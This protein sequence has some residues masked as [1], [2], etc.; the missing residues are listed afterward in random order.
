MKK[1]LLVIAVVI[2]MAAIAACQPSKTEPT[3]K[4]EGK[5]LL[6]VEKASSGGDFLTVSRIKKMGFEVTEIFDG[7]FTTESADGFDVVFVSSSISSGK[8]GTKL[9][10]SPVP[11]VYAEPQNISDIDLAGWD[12][13]VDNGTVNGKTIKIKDA[14]HPLAAGLNGNIDVYKSEGAIGFAIPGGE[15]QIIATASD[16]EKKAVL[17]ALEK[18]GK[19]LNNHP[20]PARQVFIY[21]DPDNVVYH[22]DD[23]WKL[24]EAALTWAVSGN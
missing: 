21:L 6:Y 22:T 17:F 5:K 24:L 8:V 14:N 18:G 4:L 13:T 23:G 1:V 11:V 2:A 16:D 3:V 19:N 10:N 20:V 9:Y 15:A 12:D 7:E